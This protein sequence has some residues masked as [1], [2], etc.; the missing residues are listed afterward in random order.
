M[1]MAPADQAAYEKYL[2]VRDEVAHV[3]RSLAADGDGRPS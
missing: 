3:T 1:I 2:R